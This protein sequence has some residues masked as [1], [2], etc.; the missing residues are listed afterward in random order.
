MLIRILILAGILVK[1]PNVKCVS[2]LSN[3]VTDSFKNN[4][5]MFNI[6]LSVNTKNSDQSY[7]SSVRKKRGNNF[8]KITAKDVWK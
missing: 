1:K 5:D 7:N 6:S 8:S 3:C 2:I 4:P